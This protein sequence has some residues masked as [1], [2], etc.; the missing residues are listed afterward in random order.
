MLKKKN[1]NM[2]YDIR[3]IGD[4]HISLSAYSIIPLYPIPLYPK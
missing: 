2:V 3:D 1:R 4:I